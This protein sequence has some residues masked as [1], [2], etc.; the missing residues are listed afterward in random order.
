MI[1]FVGDRDSTTRRLLEE[2]LTTE[3]KPA[4]ELVRFIEDIEKWPQRFPA[5]Q[6]A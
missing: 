6:T 4:E 2:V 5:S 1:R 3:E